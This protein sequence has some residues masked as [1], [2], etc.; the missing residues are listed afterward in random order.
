MIK[1]IMSGN[2]YSDFFDYAK[3]EI[4][5]DVLQIKLTDWLASLDEKREEE[6]REEFITNWKETGYGFAHQ[7]LVR[8][9]WG[10]YLA[11]AEDKE[12]FYA[13]WGCAKV[14][15]ERSLWRVGDRVFIRNPTCAYSTLNAR[16]IRELIR[17]NELFERAC[18]HY[19]YGALP[20]KNEGVI[21]YGC[22]GCL[23]AKNKRTS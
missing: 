8:Q 11:Q 6:Y 16:S 2:F 18:V 4:G 7:T 12:R 22:G 9:M 15:A 20:E 21:I 19:H 3:T 17:D 1:S 14:E 23:F 10:Y 5:E 13:E